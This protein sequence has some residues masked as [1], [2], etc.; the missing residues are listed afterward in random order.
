MLNKT[1][2]DVVRLIVTVGGR[3]KKYVCGRHE[4]DIVLGRLIVLGVGSDGI[5]SRH[6]CY[7]SVMM[8]LLMFSWYCLCVCP[9]GLCASASVSDIV[10]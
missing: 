7:C 2:I 6:Y 1:L 3:T 8:L 10:S 9:K 4:L 5:V